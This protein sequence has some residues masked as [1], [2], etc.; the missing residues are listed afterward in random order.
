M[1]GPAPQPALPER[2]GAVLAGLPLRAVACSGG[3]DSLLLA[4]LAHRQA[5][6]AT[7]VVHAVSP[8][9]PAAATARVRAQASAEGWALD[10]VDAGEFSD[11]DYL[12]NPVDRCFFCKQRLYSTLRQVT[13]ALDGPVAILSGTS[14]D[15]LGE[16]RP[17]L[18]AAEALGVRHPYVE[19]GIGKADIRALARVLGLAFADLPASP[20]LA[21]RLYTGLAVTPE[22]LRAVERAED[23]LRAETGLSVLRC[24]RRGDLMLIEVEAGEGARIGPGL[25]ARVAAEARAIDPGIRDLRLDPRPYAPG[26]A[27]RGAR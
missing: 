7:R 2:L 11:P 24:R 17:G 6:D 19:A 25:I 15:D 4:T 20:C 12:A 16:Y 22:R 18:R 9:V 21:S 3:I 14:A 1:P 26:R 10:L 8:A 13:A 5:P 27:F 23:R